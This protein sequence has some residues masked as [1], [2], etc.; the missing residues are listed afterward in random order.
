MV[1]RSVFY[2][3]IGLYIGHDQPLNQNEKDDEH[4]FIKSEL[5][6]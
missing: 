3:S 4:G 6:Q 5:I 2:R 1:C